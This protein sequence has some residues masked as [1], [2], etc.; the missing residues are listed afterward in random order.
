MAQSPV[1]SGIHEYLAQDRVIWGMPA[2]QAVVDECTRRGA[3]RVM[4]VASRSLNQG[5][6]VVARIRE[7][8]GEGHVGTFDG[9]REH[10]PRDTVIAAADA[11]REWRPDLIVTIGGGTAIDTVKVMQVALAHGVTRAADLHPFRMGAAPEESRPSATAEPMHCRQIVVSTTLGAA[12]FSDF[13]GCTDTERGIKDGFHGRTIGAAAVILDPA[14]TR[15]TP[16]TLWLSTGI[17]GI[18]HAVEAICSSVRSP[19]IE[20]TCLQALRLFAQG[21]P[22]TLSDPQDLQA[23]LQCQQAAWL[24]GLAILRV[25]FG[26]SHGIGHSLGAVTGMAHGYT[27]CVMLPHVM[28]FNLDVTRERQAMIAQALAGGTPSADPAEAAELVARLVQA[29]GLPGRLSECGV[30]P[31]DHPRIAAGALNNLWVRSN[32][33]PITEASQVQALLQA[34]Q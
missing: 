14:I 5:T 18:D 19:L 4:I 24:A 17:R 9:C 30:D 12:E 22:R 7:A 10:T 1:D 8:L 26:A 25:P 16:A 28:R 21:L 29:L 11:A 6:D 2:A 31:A 32:P 34:A 13:A 23:R 20:A 27:S 3:Q 33:R 15:H